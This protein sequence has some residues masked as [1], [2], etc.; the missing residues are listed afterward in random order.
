LQRHLHQVRRHKKV[1]IRSRAPLR[2]GLAGGGSD[3]SPFSETYGGFVLNATISLYARV[4]IQTSDKKVASFR[5]I[6]QGDFSQCDLS[7]AELLDGEVSLAKGVFRRFVDQYGPAPFGFDLTTC[8]DA[9]AGSGLGTSSTLVVALVAAF[10]DF[11]DVGMG[12]YDI[13]QLAFD[14]ERR[15]LKMAGGKQDQYAAAFGGFN[16]M[17]FGPGD[18]VIVNPLRLRKELISELESNLVLFYT[19][20]SRVSAKIIEVQSKN[21][22]GDRPQS[23]AAMMQLKDQAT[24]MKAAILKGNLDEVGKLLDYG[25]KLKKSTADE[26]SNSTI[27]QMYYAACEAG[28]IGGKIS[29]AGGGGF[30]MFY[31]PGT[32]RYQVI[33][34]LENYG[35]EFRNFQFSREGVTTWRS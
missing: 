31:C 28:S 6:D 29:G 7:A 8:V 23:L 33:E 1:L 12:E 21:V 19:G 15:D 4:S 13:A 35:G 30:M 10:A 11:F 14:I 5:S 20:R 24:K 3:V 9:P 18:H 27:D 34:A 22:G 32:T 17:E 25:W 2:L 16:F 26:V